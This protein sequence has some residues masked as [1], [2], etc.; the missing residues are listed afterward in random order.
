[1]SDYKRNPRSARRARKSLSRKALVVLSLMMVL[2]VAAVGGTVAWLTDK[3]D[4]VVNTFT[5]GNIDIDL[6]ETWNADGPDEDTEADH[7]EGKMIPG[8]QY[9]KDPKVTVQA[10]SEACYLFVKFT[11]SDK[12]DTYLNYTFRDD[13]WTKGDGNTIP[14]IVW[15]R[16]IDA[17]TAQ[18][19]TSFYLLKGNT[20][21]P[22]GYVEIDADAVTKNTMTEAAAV[23][24]TFQAYAVQKDNVST[25]AEAWAK[26]PTT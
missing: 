22:N 19:G 10:G 13:G 1:M 8:N 18:A 9:L 21:Y 23:T 25:A 11:E 12:A 24:L 4:P 16:E 26:V 14:A 2:A 5:V 15:Y 20:T 7:W 17:A 3:T 6:T